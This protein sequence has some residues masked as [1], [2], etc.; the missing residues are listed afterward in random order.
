M[1]NVSFAAF[2]VAILGSQALACDDHH[3]ECEVEDWTYSYTA[4]MQA[5]AIDGV[6]TCDA[7]KIRLR[8]YDGEGENRELVG[9]ETAYIEGHIFEA[10]LLPLEREPA[11]LSIRYSIQPE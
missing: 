6:S 4:M 1:R 8:L 11:A 9:V 7:G 10:I 3:G 5:L 2:V